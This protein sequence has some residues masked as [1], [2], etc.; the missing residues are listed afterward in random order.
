MG[1]AYGGARSCWMQQILPHIDQ[2]GLWESLQPSITA[3]T[4]AYAWANR[5]T[6]V[7]ALMCPTDPANPKVITAGGGSPTGSQGFHGNYVM[8]YGRGVYT[9]TPAVTT[10]GLFW[11]ISNTK[12]RD[13]IDGTSTT[14]MG[15]EIVLSPDTGTHDLRGRYYNTWQG[16][17]LFSSEYPPNTTVGDVSSYCNAMPPWAPCGPLSTANTVQYI[18]SYHQGGAHLLMA[19][20]AVRFFSENVD[21]GLFRALSTAKGNEAVDDL[22]L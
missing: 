13:I 20:G 17:V 4:G 19:D 3:G 1:G 5:W 7:P 21:V 8:S 2:G 6:V 15:G 14:F 12:F 18:R 11:P 9:N 16:N 22:S 10:R